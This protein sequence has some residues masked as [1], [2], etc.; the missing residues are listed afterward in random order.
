MKNNLNDI[1]LNSLD[2]DLVLT[3]RESAAGKALAASIDVLQQTQNETASVLAAFDA[4]EALSKRNKSRAAILEALKPAELAALER[5]RKT[6]ADYYAARQ[7]FIAD[8]NSDRLDAAASVVAERQDQ[9]TSR[10]VARNFVA[11]AKDALLENKVNTH[12]EFSV[13]DNGI[14]GRV[15]VR[16]GKVDDVSFSIPAHRGTRTDDNAQS[17]WTCVYVRSSFDGTH[18]LSTIGTCLDHRDTRAYAQAVAYAADVQA[19]LEQ[20]DREGS[21]PA[22]DL[23]DA[24]FRIDQIG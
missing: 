24:L 21:V 3:L 6:F 20:A 19:V 7:F 10:T 12:V 16:D 23:A 13:A 4:A 11:A 14:V 9:W 1:I 17:A 5:R 18:S 22:K 2:S 15:T 8:R